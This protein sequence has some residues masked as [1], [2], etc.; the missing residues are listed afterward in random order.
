[1][2]VARAVSRQTVIAL[3]TIIMHHPISITLVIFGDSIPKAINIRNLN[4]RCSTAN[5]KCSFFG[6]ATSKHFHYYIQPT[7]SET[8]VTTDIAVLHMGTKDILNAE[9]EK[10]LIAKSVT[11][12][13]TKECIRFGVKDVFVSSVTINTR[14]SSAF[15]SA[16]NILQDKFATYQFHFIDNSNIIQDG[17]HLNR[18]GKT[19]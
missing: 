5:C 10:D 16:L 12:I 2:K 11:D 3:I 1:M 19:C 7:L 17:L 4:T 6:G 15:I 9:A 8:N 18:S 14:R 13:A